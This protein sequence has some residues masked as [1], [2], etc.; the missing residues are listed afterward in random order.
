MSAHLL[1]APAGRGKTAHAISR[2]RELAP[3]SPVRVLVPD[4][5]K[6]VAFRRRLAQAG[7]AL[8]VEVQTF[9]NLYAD[10]LTLSGGSD[11]AP[12]LA[13]LTPSVRYRL[14]RHLVTRLCDA[15]QLPYHAPLRTAPAF[16]RLLVGL[17]E[18]LKR[19]RI[20][21]KD[22]VSTLSSSPSP[23]S[24]GGAGGG[25]EG[26]GGGLR[27]AEL[28][29][30]YAAYQAWLIDAGWVD[31]EGQGWLAAIALKND[32]ALLSNLS[33]LVV[34][35]FDEFNPTQL[36]VLRL[37]ADRAAE[38]LVTLIGNPATF[39]PSRMARTEE[40]HRLAHRRFA[41][42]RVAITQALGVE[43]TPLVPS[44]PCPPVPSS[45][46]PLVHLEKSLFEPN[47]TPLSA[48]DAVT[49][50]EA[51]NRAAEARESLRWLKARI[52]RDGVPLS[53]VAIVARDLGPY[54]PFL[55]EVAAEFG[56]PLR[57]ISGAP[58]R[59]NPA[60]AALLNL[61]T[62]PLESV[63]W[64]P[65]VV[66]DVLSS[67]YFD[68]ATCDLLP[69]DA[70][71]RLSAS[72]DRLGDVARAGHVVTG[73]AQWREALQ[74]LV[75]R[76]PAQD[77]ELTPVALDEEGPVQRRLPTGAEAARLEAAFEEVVA[78]VTPPAVATLRERVAW[79]EE[80]IGADP[81]L[82]ERYPAPDDV[83]LHTVA[84]AR[85]NPA[86]AERD[87][88]ALCAFKDILRSLVL[89]ES[90]IADHKPPISNIQ[91]YSH[92]AFVVEL[93]QAVEETTY[94]TP[95]VG[96]AILV[97]SATGVR[98]LTFD[99]VAL[100]G[101][102]EGDFPRAERED[103]LLREA[104]RAWLAEQGLAIEP[105]LQGDEA[106]FFYQAVTRARRRLLLCRP[107]LADDGQP[108][109][110]SPYWTAVLG[111]FSAPSVIHI[112]PTDPITDVAS[113]QE[114]AAILDP[115][116]V[117]LKPKTPRG[118]LSALT[119]RL[120]ERFGPDRPWSSSR[121]E[122]YAKC[123]FYFWAT[124]VIKLEPREPP[125]AGFDVLILGSIYHLVLERLYGR[126]PDG[127]PD[128][129][130]TLLPDVARQVYDDA[131]NEYGFRPSPLWERQQEELTEVLR[132]TLDAL[133]E[134]AG[135][136][137]P[138]VPELAFGLHE[139]PPLVLRGEQSLQLRGYIDRVDRAPDGRIRIIDYKAGSTPIP[140][141]DLTDGYRLQLPLYAMA[142]ERALDAQ[143][144]SGFYW[145]IGSAKP[146]GLK[147]EKY[148]GGVVG[149]M[150][151]AVAH[152]MQIVAAVR[153]GQFA[154][155]PP[156]SGCPAFC[157]AVTFCEQY[158][159]KTW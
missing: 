58:L 55:E 3:L 16:S 87:V 24:Q 102:A 85:D 73:L 65:R 149:A 32:P 100:L 80:L 97:A 77:A 125:R 106:T 35:G 45:P 140:A 34:D 72:A 89:A 46:P 147:L 82:T 118:D 99:S 94:K 121:L 103:V 123:P 86:T 28:A 129:L 126:V 75:A 145:H 11:D 98:G 119:A 154:P 33:L 36:E 124:Y 17:F 67:P 30:L 142:A 150:E 59:A 6:A 49:F 93:A 117:T 51:Q 138:A 132:R 44:S 56:M 19:A 62:L 70:S 53:D 68:W 61:L 88:A 64:S 2:I 8:A 54:R 104:D 96:D 107:Y 134:I 42:A 108:W 90:Q 18:E 12:H 26:R 111:L 130:R 115:Q 127:D 122:T 92:Y 109:E 136:Y 79:V 38:T 120:S 110:P 14:I 158:K 116:L 50:L 152:A 69:G 41:R 76:A 84:R 71:D 52:V 1:L 63:D 131:P 113:E 47:V 157:P 31:A 95:V 57:F 48:G 22:L 153:A 60:V 133:I 151:T 141:R 146:S 27:L 148:E 66:L 13:L 128:R 23:P 9:H 81:A 78:R 43:P 143:V 29:R 5:T 101:L 105:R 137:E 74:R 10:V 15:G 7:G 21:P 155:T 159:P 144:A 156:D 37:L 20:F 4:Q 83:S 135:D 25:W 91:S 114:R 40:E 39:P 112:R 139:R